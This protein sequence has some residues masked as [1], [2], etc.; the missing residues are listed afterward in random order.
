MVTLFVW[1]LFGDFMHTL[2]YYKTVSLVFLKNFLMQNDTLLATIKQQ[3]QRAAL[4]NRT[5][6]SISMR[7]NF[8]Q[9]YSILPR[10]EDY[11]F[12]GIIVLSLSLTST[13][14][15]KTYK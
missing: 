4:N 8:L 10:A 9:L 15:Y 11:I 14:S 6:K 2:A 1:R 3:M 5:L 7:A 13:T 12:D